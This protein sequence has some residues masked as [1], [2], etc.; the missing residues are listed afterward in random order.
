MN[1]VVELPQAFDPRIHASDPLTARWLSEAT[2][3]LRREI[4]WLWFQRGGTPSPADAR[5]PPVGDAVVDS[6]D[7]ARH[8]DEKRRFFANDAT[9]RYLSERIALLREHTPPK[10]G[11]WT[12]IAHRLQLDEA[13]Q[14]VLAVGLLARSDSATAA[15]I[16]TCHGDGHRSQ[17]SLALVQRLCDEPTDLLHMDAAHPL[18]RFG[19]LAFVD[20][21]PRNGWLQGFEMPALIASACLFDDGRLP[22]DL[23]LLTPTSLHRDERGELAAAAH[24][25]AH[26]PQEA[27]FLPLLGDRGSDYSGWAAW[28]AQA[29]GRLIVG[30]QRPDLPDAHRLAALAAWCWLHDADV[31]LP[32]LTPPTDEHVRPLVWPTTPVRWL[33]P[34]S[35]LQASKPLPAHALQAPIVLPVTDHATRVARLTHALGARATGLDAGIAEVARRFRLGATAIDAIGAA[36]S[37]FD[38]RL[39]A[40]ALQAL[41]RTQS[42]PDLGS[43]AQAVRTRFALDEMVLPAPQ[44]LQLDEIVRATRA[45]TTVHYDWGT[46]KAWNESGLS[47]LFCG[48]PG[49][50]KT[51]A[52]EAI[53]HELSLPMYRIDLSQVV[54]KYI[55]ETEKNLKRVFDVIEESDCVVFFDEADALFGKR[56][57]VKDAHDRFA[58]IEVSYLLERME[59]LKGVAILATNRR[60]DLDEAFLRRLRYLVDF[61]LPGEAE[62]QRLWRYVFPTRV[63]TS[64]LDF[65]YLAQAFPLAGGHIRSI[66]FNAC[67]QSDVGGTPRVEMATVLCAVKRELDKINR[68]ISV[69]S[70]G[71]YQS[72]V[73][74]L[75]EEDVR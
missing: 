46:A 9:G 58:N 25:L 51:M 5:L 62:R 34:M 28:L 7:L 56:T 26:P 67:L 6:L 15:I 4:A 39:D 72:L 10:T 31:L 48:P 74:A 33:A 57:S 45:L 23:R 22:P 60:K 16:A 37:T 38:G 13:A 41:C 44:R 42:R 24:T 55:G 11:P 30:M 8:A 17:P 36:A 43:L 73:A 52:A 21:T 54:N 64:T 12:A 63:D 61:P 75:F 68:P 70:F 14:L 59:R 35:D 19:L 1:A 65:A 49:T 32:T 50:G 29:S 3:R 69:E 2:L 66:A 53:A 47:A 20:D 40:E 27:C 71:R 18:F